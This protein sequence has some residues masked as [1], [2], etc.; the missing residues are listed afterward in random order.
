ML[1][2]KLIEIYHRTEARLLAERGDKP[3]WT[4]E[5]ASS[6]LSTATSVAALALHDATAHADRIQQALNWLSA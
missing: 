3:H 1:P 6:A 4:G 2:E 5:L